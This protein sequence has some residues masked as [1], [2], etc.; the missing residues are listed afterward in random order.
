ME[1]MA[2]KL[3]RILIQKIIYLAVQ[4]HS[5]ITRYFHTVGKWGM[6]KASEIAMLN[7]RQVQMLI[8]ATTRCDTSPE[9]V[10]VE[11]WENN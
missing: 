10:S 5:P 2:R 3:L 7:Q 4:S 11:Q 1:W 9:M 6:L 8:E